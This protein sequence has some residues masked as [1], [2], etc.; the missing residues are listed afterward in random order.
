MPRLPRLRTT[1]LHELAR[2]VQFASPVAARKHLARSE[3][4]AEQ[5]LTDVLAGSAPSEYPEDWVVFRVT[6]LR[7]EST[8]R[9]A[10]GAVPVG[11]PREELLGDLGALTQRL[12]LR[13]KVSSAECPPPDW[14]TA[15]E[16][17]KRWRCSRKTIERWQRAGLVSRRVRTSDAREHAVFSLPIIELID[18]LRARGEIAAEQKPAARVNTRMS[19]GERE[20]IIRR[21]RKYHHAR[22][23]SLDRCAA[24]IAERLGR[25]RQAVRKVL[26]A[27]ELAAGGPAFPARVDGATSRS[28]VLRDRRLAR[29]ARLRSLDLSAPISDVIATDDGAA[30]AVETNAARTALLMPAPFPLGALLARV[31][32]PRELSAASERAIATAYCAHMH[33][34]RTRLESTDPLHPSSAALD[35]VE[36]ALRHAGRLKA[37]L[38]I[39]E[40]ALV[41]R[42]I[43]TQIAAPAMTLNVRTLYAAVHAGIAALIESA[44]AYDPFKGGRLAAPA[45]LSVGRAVA[46]ALKHAALKAAAEVRPKAIA[47][48]ASVDFDSNVWDGVVAPWQLFL[49]PPQAV[50]QRIDALEAP[51]RELLHM[52][53]G[54]SG[55]EPRTL[56]S[57]AAQLA[58][59]LV[60]V[61]ADERT[62]L[63]LIGW[64]P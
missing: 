40:L 48:A 13:A 54:L 49:E 29:L 26:L 45:S 31:A 2:Q 28:K 64:T 11:V 9:A 57:I 53:F 62:A 15:D 51:L 1:A 37:R 32:T 50:A 55:A 59:P 52:R 61:A 60:R 39:D 16:L 58:R 19:Q 3:A 10:A 35:D 17:Q 7:T 38:V 41:V 33:L 30:K 21:A 43:E 24:R 4:L 44:G 20:L 27:S 56:R 63:R 47:R 25:S 46:T 6:G 22:G 14:L 18:K 5:V 12:S 23:W 36:T 34:A 42:T 8:R